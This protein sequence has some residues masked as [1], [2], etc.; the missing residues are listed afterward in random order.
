[1][2]GRTSR[3]G[4]DTIL[5]RLITGTGT[6]VGSELL[7]R[8]RDDHPAETT[9]VV[10]RTAGELLATAVQLRAERELRLTEQSERD[11]VRREQLTAAARQRY[12]DELAV[13]VPD[14][15]HKVADLIDT[16][17]P[18]EYDDAVQLLVDLRDLSERD[19]SIERFQLQLVQLRMLHARKPSL[20]ERLDVVGLNA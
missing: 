4:E 12:L 7:R 15:W 11:R 10:S 18:R 8:F 19:G 6:H 14:A 1:M 2:G 17:K 20:L 16:K 13:D 5:T 9:S 3:S